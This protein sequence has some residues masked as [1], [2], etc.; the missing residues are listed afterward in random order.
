MGRHIRD[1]VVDGAR[2]REFP[3]PDGIRVPLLH[4]SGSHSQQN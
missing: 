2:V 4:R 1:E 3:F